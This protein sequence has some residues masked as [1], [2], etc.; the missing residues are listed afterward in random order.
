MLSETEAPQLTQLPESLPERGDAATR[1]KA[2]QDQ[3]GLT[4]P[5]QMVE[6]YG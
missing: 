4:Q 5:A 3:L 1:L 2:F 6:L